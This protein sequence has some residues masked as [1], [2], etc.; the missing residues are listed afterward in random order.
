MASRPV[1]EQERQKDAPSPLRDREGVVTSSSPQPRDAGSTLA[2][3]D[4]QHGEC[5][6][7]VEYRSFRDGCDTC[8]CR[9]RD[10]RVVLN[11]CWEA[12]SAW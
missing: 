1:A 8:T 2:T 11:L 6:S 3:T 12:D 10:Q 5:T 7:V 9:T 4:R